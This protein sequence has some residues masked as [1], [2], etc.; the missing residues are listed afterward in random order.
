MLCDC[1]YHSSLLFEAGCLQ[2]KI[3]R[4]TKAKTILLMLYNCIDLIWESVPFSSHQIHIHAPKQFLYIDWIGILPGW[5]LSFFTTIAVISQL[6]K[7]FYLFSAKQK[8]EA[9]DGWTPTYVQLLPLGGRL[10][11]VPFIHRLMS[12]LHTS[13]LSIITTLRHC[14]MKIRDRIT[15]VHVI[16]LGLITGRSES[17]QKSIC[18]QNP[19]N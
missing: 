18:S 9:R 12:P 6:R 19:W 15:S 17:G 10:S 2:V 13:G 8:L 3:M 7:L 14:Y 16:V 4:L 5:F 11:K 1:I